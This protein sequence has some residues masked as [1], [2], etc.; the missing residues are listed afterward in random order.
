M[1]IQD[2]SL[3]AFSLTG[4]V[5]LITGG[6]SGLG[7]AM[8]TALAKAGASVFIVSVEEDRQCADLLGKQGHTV[9]QIKADLR[10]T[11]GPQ[12]IVQQCVD[13]LGRL[14]ILVNCAGINLLAEVEEFDRPLWDATLDVN[15]TAAFEMSYQAL[16]HMRKQG[17]G[18]IINICSVFSFLGGRGS[19]AYAATKH[20][21]AGLTKAYCDELAQDNIQ[22]NGIA[23]GYFATKLTEQTRSNPETNAAVLNHIPAGRWGERLNHG[24]RLLYGN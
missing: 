14:D 24:R 11:G 13:D 4:K 21:L 6:N 20:G 18:K 3:K 7:E 22:V 1:A 19:A 2:F 15:L 8:T 23:P 5:A 9:R 12:S 10:E 16:P 17:R